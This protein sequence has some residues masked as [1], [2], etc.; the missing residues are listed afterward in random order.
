MPTNEQLLDIFENYLA[1]TEFPAEPERLYAPI[2]YSLSGGG[3][4]LRPM[5]LLLACGVFSD[6]T[7]HALPA[8]AAVE[9]FHNFT[10]L[11]D[12]IMDNAAVRR[13]KPSV[14]AR[15]G[16]NVAILSGDAMMI[17]AYRLLSGVPADKLPRILA[18][19]NTMAVEVCEGQQY[20][21]DF[22]QK[23][24]VSVVE[25]MH[26]IEL[27]TSVLLGGAVTIGALLGGASEEDCRKLYRFAIEL[28]LAFQLQDDQL[29]S[30]GDERLGKAIG[31]DILEGKQTYLMIT[32]MSRA[33]EPAREI[34]RHTY[35]DD[36]LC[37]GEKIAR[38]K[39]VYDRLEIPRLT[40]QQI[41]VRFE[42]ALALLDT[43]SVDAAR[44]ARIREFA[45]G[46]MNRK[47]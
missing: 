11:H 37:D 29:D 15:W 5:L 28:G 6:R 20:D 36:T 9:I 38:V 33:D 44:T 35:K 8:A 25:Y 13:G 42:R 1:Q 31:G 39:A 18:M 43:L 23:P 45:V 14:H 7:D 41:T 21:M 19:F 32:A 4:R 47:K 10:L 3:K 16:E 30:Y 2:R 24:K 27:K 26:M 22:E 40:E 34:L 17:C 12:D 46:L